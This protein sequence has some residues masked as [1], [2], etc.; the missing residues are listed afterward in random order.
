ME[1]LQ[2]AIER[3]RLSDSLLH[4]LD[5]LTHKLPDLTTLQHSN[6]IRTRSA[7]QSSTTCSNVPSLLSNTFVSRESDLEWI[8]SVLALNSTKPGSRRAAIFGMTGV[9]K[10][11]LVYVVNLKSRNATNVFNQMLK[12][13]ELY[14]SEY[15]HRFWVTSGS[16]AKVEA[17]VKQLLD[18]LDIPGRRES[19]PRVRALALRAWL[20]TSRGWLL[21][22]DNVA[23]EDYKSVLDVLPQGVPL[24]DVILT[25]QR[26]GAMERL[27]GNLKTRCLRLE[28]FQSDEAAD[29]F[30]RVSDIERTDENRHHVREIASRNGLLPQAI[31]QAAAYVKKTGISLTDYIR[32]FEDNA[33]RVRSYHLRL[34]LY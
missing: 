25:S 10:S 32:I 23:E 34:S 2:A 24:G 9:G 21:M 16:R 17:G 12:Y 28:G 8:A 30:Y 26:P 29:L 18:L 11:Q 4:E 7:S 33:H 27:T 20:E 15:T 5:I 3:R 31:N 13:E 22:F 6:M 1:D 14:R 19:E